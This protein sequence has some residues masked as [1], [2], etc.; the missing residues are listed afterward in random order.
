MLISSVEI[1]NFRGI[2]ARRKFDFK[3]RK[4]ILL[5]AEN[6]VGKTTVID[7]IEWGLTGCIGRLKEAFE[8]RSSNKEE[9]KVNGDGILKNK[10]AT[11]SEY[12]KIR[13]QIVH[14]DQEYLIERTQRN[15]DF[16]SKSNV[17]V[18]DL[19]GNVVSA[20]FL[21][22]LI[23]YNFYNYHFCDI[24]KAYN[25][26]NSDRDK[27]TNVFDMFITDY[28]LEENIASNLETVFLTD[29]ER[30]RDDIEN[31]RKELKKTEEDLAN[32]I[33][34]KKNN[35]S[36]LKYDVNVIYQGECIEVE[37][38]SL[39]EIEKQIQ[40]LYACGWQCLYRK[41]IQLLENSRNKEIL[42]IL[43]NMKSEYVRSEKFI[44]EYIDCG[45][46][47]EENVLVKLKKKLSDLEEIDLTQENYDIYADDIIAIEAE[48]F[49]QDIWGL[50]EQKVEQKNEE[51]KR[52]EDDVKV[53][54]DGNEVIEAL[55]SMIGLKIDIIAYRKKI[56]KDGVRVKCP[57]CGSDDFNIISE[58]YILQEAQKYLDANNKIIAD[59]KMQLSELRKIK[60]SEI[61]DMIQKMV[62][63]QKNE[64][65]R[66]KVEIKKY[67]D[68][69][70]KTKLFF[71]KCKKYISVSKSDISLIS[72]FEST[73]IDDL[74]YKIEKQ[75]LDIQIVD[76]I[77]R[78]IEN[79]IS[80]VSSDKIDFREEKAFLFI[81][82]KAKVAPEILMFDYSV[83]KNKIVVLE[84]IQK[85]IE[86]KEVSKK[87][88]EVKGKL[89]ACSEELL[90]LE[91]VHKKTIER[92]KIIRNKILELK[93]AEY[94]NVGP[95]LFKFY[96]KLARINSI[97]GIYVSQDER[98]RILLKDTNEDGKN[99]V[100]ILSNGQMSIFVLSCFF[101][102]LV[103]R[104]NDEKCKIY[105][106]DDLTSCMD[107]INMLAF[108]DILKYELQEDDVM[109][110]LFFASCNERVS[111]LLKYKLEGCRIEYCEITEKDFNEA[112]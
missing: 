112:I 108:L 87:Y 104:S 88:D 19:N 91:G 14:D 7:A 61:K 13:L 72:F 81:E 55:T 2:H 62:G 10:E 95:Y 106:I 100:N 11:A 89:K 77:T 22:D 64:C 84:D 53:M 15:D 23:D 35:T 44:V 60:N 29:I 86:F 103:S 21:D 12:V 68:L 30:K 25:I 42:N 6:G 109:E 38:L 39:K 75:L 9:R 71:E 47:N 58:E 4:F 26:Q 99:I 49:N 63:V 96:R 28:T 70:D 94:D 57:V 24:Q 110:Q 46:H 17:V 74:Y 78:E 40:N 50:H 54:T 65:N 27:L 85:N 93:K 1:E 33:A 76:K 31:N 43:E 48:E 98:K 82:E 34:N 67:E 45:L 20:S 16:S 90:N 41:S 102:G 51:I 56:R 8:N 36:I 69:V 111:E 107:D 59:K 97:E 52:L 32:K 66:L 92:V 37:K 5:S 73:V 101:G 79:I 105:F 18:K 3:N 83:W 80:I